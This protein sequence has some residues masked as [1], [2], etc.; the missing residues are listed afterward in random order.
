[1]ILVDTGVMLFA[2][3]RRTAGVHPWQLG[4]RRLLEAGETLAGEAL[5]AVQAIADGIPLATADSDYR[6][7]A[8][9][10]PMLQLHTLEAAE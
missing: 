5:I 2:L 1:M 10:W 3:G 6:R 4:V 8:S 9:V 7:I